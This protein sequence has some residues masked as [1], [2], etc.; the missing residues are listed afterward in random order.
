MLFT[1]GKNILWVTT[2]KLLLFEDLLCPQQDLV[3][4]RRENEPISTLRSGL[5]VALVRCDP[6]KT[7]TLI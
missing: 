5:W 4:S 1:A 6:D 7:P 3:N 2:L